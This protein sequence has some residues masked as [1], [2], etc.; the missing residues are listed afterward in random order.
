MKKKLLFLT[1]LFVF[2]MWSCSKKSI[3]TTVTEPALKT[4]KDLVIPGS[5]N[6]ITSNEV[7]VGIHVK[8]SNSNLADVPVSIYLDYP[9]STES[10]NANARLVGTFVSQSDGRIDLILK[11]PSSQ[12]SLYLVTKYIGLETEAG[13]AING[14]TA[15]YNYGEG[16]TIKSAN[17]SVP[18]GLQ[19]KTAYLF[20][21]LGTFDSQGVP[22]YLEKVGDIIPQSLLNDVNASLPERIVLPVSHPQYLAKGNEGAV[23]LKEPADVWITFLSEGAGYL[24]AIGYYTYDAQKPPTKV[25]EISKLNVIFP[26]SSLPGSGGGLKSGSKVY[27]GR[28][29]TGQAIGWFLVPNGWSSGKVYG[30]TVYFSD[31][32]LNPEVKPENRQHTVLLHDNLRQLVILGFEDINREN[33]SDNDFNDA[34]FYVTANPPSAI[35]VTAVPLIDTPLDDDKDG[36]SNSF[37]EFPSDPLRTYTSYY[38]GKGQYNSLLVEDLWPSLGDFDFNDMVIDCNY[39]QVTNAKSNIVELFIK[40]KL[41][42]IGASF[43]NGFGIQLPVDAT[44]VSS[45]VLTDQSGAAKK[46]SLETGQDKAVVIAFEDA[47][48]L[49]PSTGG[50]GVNVIPGNGWSEPKEIQFHILFSTPQTP[51]NMGSAP[52]NPFVYVNGDRTKEI[53]LAGTK[54]TSKASAKFFGQGDDTTNPATSRYY[55][56]KNN[57]I[58]MMEVPSSFQYAIERN[59]LTKVYLKLGA[60]AESGGSLFKDW[61]MDKPGYIESSLIFKK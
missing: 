30:T 17:L 43:K 16:N 28:F 6:F 53:H 46:I 40:L 15:S 14:N 10:P 25:S 1:A 29:E 23:V 51:A 60:W 50:M 2:G 18:A 13:F 31:P 45:V 55:K 59:D 27:L 33:G 5:F 7:A 3:V 38:P 22:N 8:N 61:Y 26:N 52:Y 4:M 44:L 48:T 37:D 47:S 9:G 19:K 56:S 20:N 21:Y 34:L 32:I 39:E 35:D 49:L 58:W 11:L 54:P 36:V 41:R 57:L 12:D 42:A 24:N